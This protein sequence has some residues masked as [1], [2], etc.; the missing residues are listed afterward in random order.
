M[1][2]RIISKSQQAIGAFNGGQIIENKP[3]GFPQ[4]GGF[5]RPYSNLFY[6]AK[7]HGVVD[8]TIGLHPHQ[9]FEIITFVLKGNIR[10]FDSQL[11]DW[12][13]LTAGDVQ[14][15][16]AGNGIEHAEHLEKDSEIFQIWFDPNLNKTL[17]QEASYNDYQLDSFPKV[18]TPYGTRRQLI[19]GEA[20]L[21]LDSPG[22]L[23][24]R[25]NFESAGELTIPEGKI[26]SLYVL[27]GSGTIG[28]KSV[29]Q[30]DFIIGDSS[31][32]L[33]VEPHDGGMDLFAIYSLAE[34]DYRT[35]WERQ[36]RYA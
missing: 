25:Y 17:Q 12:K 32:T 20:P 9:G 26:M 11:N 19:G 23:V 2:L 6:W 21:T 34:L 4:E 16:R 13:P 35:Y 18:E 1:A 22:L 33:Q 24:E 10:H 15:I 28:E 14:I 27:E 3:I 36:T 30:D 31:G 7:A 5:V 29:E 8:S